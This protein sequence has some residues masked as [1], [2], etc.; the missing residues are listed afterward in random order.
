MTFDESLIKEIKS[1]LDLVDLVSGYLSL[2]KTGRHL[3]GLCPFHQEK[4]P[5][6]TVNPEK[7]I[8]YC[9]GCHEGG[10]LFRF[11]MQ[12]ERVGFVEA[13]E[14]LALKAGLSLEQGKDSGISRQ[15]K[16]WLY[17]ANRVAAW[18]YHESLKKT[19]IAQRAQDYLKQRG[20]TPIEIEKFRLGY[21]PLQGS[22]LL[23]LLEQKGVSLEIGVRAGVLRQGE[24]GVYEPFRGRLIFP[25]F[26][27]DQ[28][29]VGLGGRVLEADAQAAKYIN[30]AESPIYDKSALLFG[31]PCAKETLRQKK[32]A[33][34]CEGY[35]DVIS[36]HQF[37]FSEAVA[38]LGTALT[39]KQ[40]GLIQ[41]FAEE[42]ILVFDGDSAGLKA[43]IRSLD[44]FLEQETQPKI[45][46]LPAGEDPDS[47][48]RKNSAQALEER[49][50]S[51][52][53]LLSFVVDKTIAEHSKDAAGKVLALSKLKPALLKLQKP[54]ERNLCLR[55]VAEKLEVPEPWVWAELGF[56]RERG[57]TPKALPVQGR[58]PAKGEE[59]L[60]EIFLKFEAARARIFDKVHPDDFLEPSLKNLACFLWGQPRLQ[61]L[62]VADLMAE[63][64]DPVLQKTMARLAFQERVLDPNTLNTLIEDCVSHLKRASLKRNLESLSAEIREAETYQQ[65]EKLMELIEQKRQLLAQNK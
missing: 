1:R 35:L 14:R 15:E 47:F 28:K 36:L 54:I 16:E 53:N 39:L 8:F 43:A 38:P 55:Q 25:I 7:Q 42:I 45:A 29:V 60:L 27:Q 10:D 13:V 57:I 17:Q 59:V 20:L 22:E 9:F 62:A 33:L 64:Q 50:K 46:L 3:K 30:S 11:F 63:T 5:S 34:L 41:R 52:R 12:M 4:T 18:Y 51:A 19:A 6:F 61:A 44:L 2:K 32:R 24:R 31:L 48:L 56:Q 58:N 49:L 21:A 23:K 37:G 40:I 65:Q 26:N